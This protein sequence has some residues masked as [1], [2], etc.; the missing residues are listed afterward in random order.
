MW[1]ASDDFD[2]GDQL[3]RKYLKYHG[4]YYDIGTKVKIKIGPNQTTETIFLGWSVNRS[5]NGKS[6]ECEYP[7][8]ERYHC[9]ATEQYIVEIINPVYPLLKPIT[10]QT[11]NRNCPNS[12]DV[13]IAWVW[14][15]LIMIVGAI[16]KDRWI[17]WIFGTLFFFAWKNGFLNGG[18]K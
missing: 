14:Y 6:F 8:S 2:W 11:T 1:F 7:Y 3:A 12:W 5:G 17:I 4:Q 18:T 15:V 16:F 10:Q 9:S 13:E